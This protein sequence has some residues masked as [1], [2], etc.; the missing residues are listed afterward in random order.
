MIGRE[1][2]GGPEY[3]RLGD[4]GENGGSFAKTV[5]PLR[6][7]GVDGVRGNHEFGIC[8]EPDDW[9]ERTFDTEADR[10]IPSDLG[11]AVRRSP[12]H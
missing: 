10:F 4:I 8:H 9:I 1:R 5:A 12:F 7:V 11:G 2:C 3:R 6:R